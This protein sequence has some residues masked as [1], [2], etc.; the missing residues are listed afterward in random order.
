M[1]RYSPPETALKT[2]AAPSRG[3]PGP[4]KKT[5]RG[6]QDE[7]GEPANEG[8][9]NLEMGMVVTN[10]Q[11]IWAELLVLNGGGRPMKREE[12]ETSLDR[13]ILAL[14]RLSGGLKKPKKRDLKTVTDTLR[15]I[16]DYR[17]RFPRCNAVNH[18]LSEQAQKALNQL[19]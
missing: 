1:S 17:L 6:L 12:L 10:A 13:S 2:Q 5:A 3:P 18:K 19:R 9:S 8:A 7:P 16:L 15:C 11:M 4:P 14:N